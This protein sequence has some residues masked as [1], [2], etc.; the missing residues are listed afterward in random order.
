MANKPPVTVFTYGEA[1]A[2]INDGYSFAQATLVPPKLE[3]KLDGLY[4]CTQAY[5]ERG[6]ACMGGVHICVYIDDE[7]PKKAVLRN[8]HGIHI[9]GIHMLECGDI[10]PY[11][12][13]IK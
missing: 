3:W 11:N 10:L 6:S 7:D 12:I 2:L 5:A 8:R 4:K 13:P 9:I 1:L